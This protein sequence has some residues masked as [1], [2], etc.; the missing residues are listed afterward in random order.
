MSQRTRAKKRIHTEI[1]TESPGAR[2]L[3]RRVPLQERSR[4]RVDAILDALA[5]LLDERGFEGVT[6]SAIA[7]RA[8]IPIG[9]VYHFFPSKE[10]ILAEL[11]SR[12]FQA[13]DTALATTLARD[14]ERQPWRPAL[15]RAI[16]NTVAAFRSDPAY[17]TVWRAMRGSPSFRAAALASDERLAGAVQALPLLASIPPARAQVLTRTAIHMGN[18]FLDWVLET[19][20]ARDAANIVREFK[21][22]LIAYLAPDLD[23]V[24]PPDASLR[25]NA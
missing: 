19:R 1:E 6:T 8:G 24:S 23:S 21:R 25:Q 18:S 16:E 17:V 2:L 9:S 13:V 15:E 12:K 4:R 14:L 5:F 22:A 10:G 11:A 7:E 3:P 20:D